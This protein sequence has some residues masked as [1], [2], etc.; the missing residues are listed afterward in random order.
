MPASARFKVAYL[1]LAG[2]LCLSGEHSSM[3][4]LMLFGHDALAGS[5][6]P[7]SHLITMT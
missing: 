7:A 3:G 2:H 4:M 1:H 5:Q 6:P